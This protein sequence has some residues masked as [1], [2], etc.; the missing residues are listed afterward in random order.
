MRP[1]FTGGAEQEKKVSS[2]Q[3]ILVK[4]PLNT[5]PPPPIPPQN[6]VVIGFSQIQGGTKPAPDPVINHPE[7]N[8]QDSQTSPASYKAQS[9]AICPVCNNATPSGAAFCG[10]CGNK[11]QGSQGSHGQPSIVCPNCHVINNINAKYCKS[12]GSVISPTAPR[13]SAPPKVGFSGNRSSTKSLWIG[14]AG[15][16]AILSLICF[17]LP[18]QVIKIANPLAWLSDGPE[19]ISFSMSGMQLLTMSAPTVKGLGDLGEFSANAFDELDMGD[20]LYDA[21]D[22]TVKRAL[23]TQRI[24]LG[25]LI[26]CAVATILVTILAYKTPGSQLS[27]LMII[28]GGVS[29]LILLVSTFV[30]NASFKTGDADADLLLN[31]A[32][33]FSNGIGFW[34]M[35]VGFIGFGLGGFLKNR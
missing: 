14:L 27:K 2:T 23:V 8:H 5:S 34:G 9:G 16:G 20:L 1:L 6:N 22:P 12:C 35:L 18:M 7:N 28:L 33:T 17:F 26:C 32:I 11:I 24:F 13:Y 25:L 10:V 19:N 31:S 15:L 30:G 21:A 3:P 29:I 4:Q